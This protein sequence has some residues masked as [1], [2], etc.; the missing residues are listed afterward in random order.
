MFKN[1]LRVSVNELTE[2]QG[3]YYQVILNEIE[4]YA[5]LQCFLIKQDISALQ[6]FAI[7]SN[8]HSRLC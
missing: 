3:K 8:S 4:E 1:E 7:N 6:Q 5:T 2:V